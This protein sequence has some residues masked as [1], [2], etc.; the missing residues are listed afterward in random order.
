MITAN[1]S[2]IYLSTEETFFLMFWNFARLPAY[3]QNL[4]GIP[5][6]FHVKKPRNSVPSLSALQCSNALVCFF[7]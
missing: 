5:V 4:A 2:Q 7:S 1:L 3:R 6:K